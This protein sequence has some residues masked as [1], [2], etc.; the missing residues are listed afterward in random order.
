MFNLS[1][2]NNIM[3]QIP[4]QP[5]IITLFHCSI[6]YDCH[7]LAGEWLSD[8]SDEKHPY[9]EW[10][11]LNDLVS[12]AAEGAETS[13]DARIVD[14]PGGAACWPYIEISAP[15]WGECKAMGDAVIACIL[16]N[17]GR[18]DPKSPGGSFL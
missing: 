12:R 9:P 3:K 2:V 18:I 16:E 6:S 5:K 8:D 14:Y 11:Q 7:P 17:G 4:P 13:K 15:T 1:M 10:G